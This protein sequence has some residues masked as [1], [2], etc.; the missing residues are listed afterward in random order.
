MRFRDRAADTA[1]MIETAR[2]LKS[3]LAFSPGARGVA[4]VSAICGQLD[5][6]AAACRSGTGSTP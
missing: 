2:A 5:P 3:A 4:V 1:R 6:E